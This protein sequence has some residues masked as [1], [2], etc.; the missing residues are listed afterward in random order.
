MHLALNHNFLT[1]RRS[2]ALKAS[3]PYLSKKQNAYINRVETIARKRF[4]LRDEGFLE[5]TKNFIIGFLNSFYR[6][7]YEHPYA[8]PL[9]ATSIII[10]C[11]EEERLLNRDVIEHITKIVEFVRTRWFYTYKGVYWAHSAYFNVDDILLFIEVDPEALPTVEDITALYLYHEGEKSVMMSSV[12]IFM[13]FPWAA[14]QIDVE[15]F[16]KSWQ[17][18]LCPPCNPDI[19]ELLT[20]KEFCLNGGRYKPVLSNAW[21]PLVDHFF[22]EE[23]M[24]FRRLIE[25]PSIYKLNSFDFIRIFWKTAQLVIVNNAMR[26]D[27]IICPLTLGAIERG[28]ARQRIPIPYEIRPLTE[29]S[30]DMFAGG[31][32]DISDQIPFAVQYLRD[33]SR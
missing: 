30:V 11:P 18:V 19:F 15:D 2:Q 6:N 21:T 5:D 7:F 29:A 27:Q 8:R 23:K 3:R 14:Y 22:S 24:L 25:D 16:Q 9:R 26:E 17:S 31:E 33:I 12:Y 20:R 13:L 28:L 32:G 4:R 10:D 1:F